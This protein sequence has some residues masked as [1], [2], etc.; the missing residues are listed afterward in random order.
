MLLIS[1]VQMEGAHVLPAADIGSLREDCDR[2]ESALA[3]SQIAV[4]DLTTLGESNPYQKS[5]NP[6]EAALVVRHL[7]ATLNSVIYGLFRRVPGAE[8]IAEPLRVRWIDAFFP[9]T[10]PSFEVEVMYMG[11]WLELLGCGVVQQA[12]LQRAGPSSSQR[13]QTVAVLDLYSLQ[14]CRTR[15][16]GL[17][18]SDSNE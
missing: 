16:A 7:K 15:W 6:A 10:T 9:F 5:H 18:A 11:E 2:L 4:E 8:A 12:T 13:C 3:S 1:S 14:G 17:S